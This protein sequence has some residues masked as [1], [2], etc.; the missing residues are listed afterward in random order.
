MKIRKILPG[1][2]VIANLAA[3]AVLAKA[4]SLLVPENSP[5]LLPA[6]S[7][8]NSASRTRVRRRE[9]R[10][11][12]TSS[13]RSARIPSPAP[14]SGRDL[15]KPPIRPGVG[16]RPEGYSRRF[17]SD[18]GIAAI[19]TTTRYALSEA[20]K[21]DTLY[22]RCECKGVLPR[23]RHAVISTLTARRGEDGHR[24]FSF[25]PLSRRMQAR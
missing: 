5:A 17:G 25:P 22:Y 19:S 11:A 18:F 15:A 20:F 13:T 12:T 24:V 9:R 10:S 6:P 16:A 1:L 4:Q 14:R 21:E 2:L 8:R 7:R 23:L 3:L